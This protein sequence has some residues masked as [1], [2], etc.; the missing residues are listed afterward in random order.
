MS[1]SCYPTDCS[2][3]GSS[4][5]G[6]SQA[7]ILEWVAISFT[8]RIFPI[9]G[10][11]RVSCIAARFFTDWATREAHFTYNSYITR[12]YM[13]GIM[14]QRKDYKWQG[15]IFSWSN[16]VEPT[17]LYLPVFW[18]C[19]VVFRPLYP[20]QYYLPLLYANMRVI[21][22]QVGKRY[23]CPLKC[24]VLKSFFFLS[25]SKLICLF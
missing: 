16:H 10:S 18:I 9:Q 22:N 5:R 25:F 11:N 19:H 12:W 7:R 17:Y 15:C 4:A 20:G 14:L 23:C 21:T 6:I 1:D 3:P 2:P 13:M 8:R 24:S